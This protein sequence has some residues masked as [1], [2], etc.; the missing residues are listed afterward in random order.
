MIIKNLNKMFKSILF[1]LS[2]AI[3]TFIILGGAYLV[4]Q[5]KTN[6]G[7]VEIFGMKVLSVQTNQASHI[8]KFGD[9]VF[10]QTGS[11]VLVGDSVSA[12]TSSGFVLGTVKKE[13]TLNGQT[14]FVIETKSSEND[15]YVR[16]VKAS[17]IEGTVSKK[18]GA[19]G[20]VFELL[21]RYNFVFIL[22]AT[23][24]FFGELF[25]I[26]NIATKQK[27]LKIQC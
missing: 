18:V 8:A 7:L 23:V 17:M 9:L 2:I 12:K 16:V 11:T 14:S 25:G 20:S 4:V 21:K 1:S 13:V 26:V 15:S 19:L 24:F 5:S 3:L 22:L 6:G 27:Y 10:L